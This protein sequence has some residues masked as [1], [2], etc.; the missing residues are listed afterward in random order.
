[1]SYDAQHI[2]VLSGIEAIR[3][4]PTL[5]IGALGASG[6]SHLLT[7]VVQN[8]VDEALAGHNGRIAVTG[9]A[10]GTWTVEDAGRGIPVDP[11]PATGRPALEVVVSTLHS[12]GKFWGGAYIA[13]GGLH[14]VG[15]AAVNA[16]SSAFSVEVR[17]HGE[18]HRL[19][20]ARGQILSPCAP[21]GPA[22]GRGTTVSFRPDPSIFG[23]AQVDLAALRARLQAQAFL[24]PGLSV[25]LTLPDQSW[26]W[27]EPEG[28]SGLVRSHNEGRELVHP[29][30]IAF[31]G[32]EG[33]VSVQVAL[34]WTQGWSEDAH[35]FVNGIHTPKGGAHADG[36]NAA[37][38]RVLSE[39]AAGLLEEGEALSGI[40]LREG[41][42]SAL[43]LRMPVPA[44]DGQAKA[45]LASREVE[46]LV[47]RLVEAGLRAA[48]AADPALAAA[49][50]GRALEAGRAR[51]ASRR[52]SARAR[53]RKQNLRVDHA[54]YREQF[55]IR[56]KNWHQSARWITDQTLLGAHAALCEAP[57]DAV[58]LDICCGSGVVGASFKG[59]V[60]HI[61]GLDLTPEMAALARTRL[62]DVVLADVY[63]IPFPEGRFD[64][65]TNRE[66]LHLFPHPERPV[67]E[68]FRVLKPGGQF[69]VGQLVP[70]SAVDAPWF[71]RV[72]KKKQ[73][74]FYNNFL[75]RDMVRLLEAA[76]FVD[77]H[78]TEV[79]Q[80]EDIDTWI[81]TW[82]TPPMMRHQIRDLYHHAPAE[83]RAVHPFEIREDGV[84][85][86]CW[87][88]CVF[89]AKKP[90]G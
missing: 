34:Q 74:L 88:W 20:C 33:E 60:G 6:V 64:L 1:M 43:S 45:A 39:A 49:V 56:S 84:I 42:T 14:G 46:P 87:R 36:F 83:V 86:D 28:L 37:L 90:A 4:R 67:S 63:D 58:V 44:F 13:P 59:K 82:E 53:Y 30:P 71:F 8:A 25:S 12:G 75:D 32:A 79:L 10:D 72:L 85:W 18:A 55:G 54:V 73:P 41:L 22:E 57:V 24:T 78:Y 7:E 52:A 9:A 61:T 11:H 65:V 76:G 38:L 62:D 31:S 69:I 48:F 68:V 3:L 89:S 80:W 29:A 47:S 19:V 17:R 81:D 40:D 35:S 23:E 77:I 21:V 50:V 16:L 70:Y 5:F 51:A 27:C 15:L 26:S 2:V 66:V